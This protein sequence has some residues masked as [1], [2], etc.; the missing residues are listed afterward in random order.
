MSAIPTGQWVDLH[1]YPGHIYA[2]YRATENCQ[3]IVSF[4]VI[5]LFVI[6]SNFRCPVLLSTIPGQQVWFTIPMNF[7]SWI[8][9]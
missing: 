1:Y 3:V 4:L 7:I 2:A 5:F 6:Y 8:S 9:R